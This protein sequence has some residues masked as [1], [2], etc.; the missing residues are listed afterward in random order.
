MI[1]MSKD[2]SRTR[3]RDADRDPRLERRHH[4]GGG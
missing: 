3:E 4:M 1:Q 2:V